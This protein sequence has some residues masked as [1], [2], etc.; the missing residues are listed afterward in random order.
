MGNLS[1]RVDHQDGLLPARVIYDRTCGP[2]CREAEQRDQAEKMA[3]TFSVA[4]GSKGPKAAVETSVFVLLGE[5][6]RGYTCS[7]QMVALRQ[8]IAGRR[9]N[10][11]FIFLSLGPAAGSG[12]VWADLQRR[13]NSPWK[14]Q[15]AS[16]QDAESGKSMLSFATDVELFRSMLLADP[17]LDD[18]VAFKCDVRP[19]S[20][21]RVQV[22][23]TDE[24]P[25]SLLTSVL[26]DMLAMQEGERD[27]K[28]PDAAAWAQDFQNM[29]DHDGVDAD[30]CE[31]AA[32]GPEAVALLQDIHEE[33]GLA[34][35]QCDDLEAIM[36]SSGSSG[37][38]GDGDGDGACP[39]PAGEAYSGAASSGAGGAAR[40]GRAGRRAPQQVLVTEDASYDRFKVPVRN[41]YHVFNQDGFKVGEIHPRLTAEKYTASALCL[42]PAHKA[43]CSRTRGW[44][45]SQNET[46]HGVDRVLVRWLWDASR[47]ESTSSHMGAPRM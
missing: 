25:V 7:A 27:Q 6:L 30:E 41:V 37:S 3:E 40:T 43:R 24:K 13:V 23:A 28:D 12:T 16:K 36:G 44:K 31:E 19:A 15:L 1:K 34:G 39:S 9:G 8:H 26:T 33:I 4:H 5:T 32:A 38:D 29:L 46:P 21:D 47:H 22:M 17:A 45:L 14:L 2:T 35:L 11:E 18:V 42:C 10:S 20:Y